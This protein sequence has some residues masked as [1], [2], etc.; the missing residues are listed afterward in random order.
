MDALR[1]HALTEHAIADRG[2][3]E[4]RDTT[5]YSR[6]SIRYM[7]VILTSEFRSNVLAHAV[8]P[9]TRGLRIVSTAHGW[10]A[11]DLRRGLTAWTTAFCCSG[12]TA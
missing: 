9:A 3:V 4:E 10:I 6:S 11:N 12:S 5:I 8:S 1:E 7:Y 2:G